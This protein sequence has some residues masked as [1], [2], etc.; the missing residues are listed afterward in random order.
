MKAPSVLI[1]GTDTAVGKTFLTA[2]LLSSLVR[3]NLRVAAFKPV[4]TGCATGDSG[5]LVAGDANILCSFANS[6]QSLEDVVF[7]KFRKALAPA[8]AADKDGVKIDVELVKKRIERFASKFDVLVVEGAGGLLVPLSWE[9]NY[10]QL[11]K[12]CNMSIIIVV[13]SRLGCLNHA[14]LTFEVCRNKNLDVIGYVFNDLFS[15]GSGDLTQHDEALLTNRVSLA[16]IAHLYGIKEICY[17]PYISGGLPL[18]SPEKV[19][20]LSGVV[21]PLAELICAKA[22]SS[23]VYR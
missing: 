4:E 20:R 10:A 18:G 21:G 6:N 13:G 11:A 8:V 19:H 22:K 14:A 12:Q 7:Y 17:L 1:T 2:L 23:E 3:N 15:E 9:C 5:E 16:K